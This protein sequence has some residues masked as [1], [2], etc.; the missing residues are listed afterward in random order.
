[1]ENTLLNITKGN[2][3]HT[4]SKYLSKRYIIKDFVNEFRF[5]FIV[6]EVKTDIN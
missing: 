1:M 3:W 6:V 4:Q 5:L 2:S